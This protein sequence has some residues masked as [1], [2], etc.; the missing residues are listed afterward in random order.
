M[1]GRLNNPPYDITGAS[2]SVLTPSDEDYLADAA[3]YG[4]E[5][6]AGRWIV[7]IGPDYPDVVLLGDRNQLV[8]LAT[9]ILNRLG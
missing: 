6:P 9:N 1:S 7:G 2:V 8:A 3:T 4:V 5:T